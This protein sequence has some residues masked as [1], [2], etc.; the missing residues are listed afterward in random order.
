MVWEYH[1]A[2][3]CAFKPTRFK[4]VLE[5]HLTRKTWCPCKDY[6]WTVEQATEGQ[7]DG[8]KVRFNGT[9]NIVGDHNNINS[10]NTV[11]NN[12]NVTMPVLASGSE[13]ER[14]YLK[15]HAEAII[16]T[17]V[18]GTTE[19]EADILSRFVRETWCNAEHTKLHNVCSLSAKGHEYLL[20]QMR[21]GHPHIETLA[22]RDAPEQLVTIAKK[23]MHQMAVDSCKGY[24]AS[25]MRKVEKGQEP[26]EDADRVAGVGYTLSTARGKKRQRQRIERVVACQLRQVP[27]KPS[28]RER[29]L[30]SVPAR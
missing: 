1:G 13:E 22:G 9:G 17:I 25:K 4:N 18:E 30:A 19:A 5:K 26:R 29:I 8:R 28:E 6:K 23:I 27:D 10:H 24:D 11:I 14:A 7:V 21:D 12:I 3:G 15:E 20:L 2:P 16:K